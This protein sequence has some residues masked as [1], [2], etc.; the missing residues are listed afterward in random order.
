MIRN[1]SA[2]KFNVGIS[3]LC[4]IWRG[5]ANCRLVSRERDRGIL[6][7]TLPSFW[8]L[9]FTSGFYFFFF[10]W[11]TVFEFD[12]NKFK[13]FGGV[14][15]SHVDETWLK[16]ELLY[17]T[18]YVCVQVTFPDNFVGKSSSIT[19]QYNYGSL[20]DTLFGHRFFSHLLWV[21]HQ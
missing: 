10:I 1:C 12:S 20:E 13:I 11:L 21:E 4:W 7:I 2:F 16:I 17:W 3:Y 14:W 18:W 6:Y 19:L 8:M 15:V 9:S 5:K